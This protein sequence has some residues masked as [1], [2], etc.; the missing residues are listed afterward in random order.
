M[1]SFKLSYWLPFALIFVTGSRPATA[2]PSIPSGGAYSAACRLD[3]TDSY[4]LG[5]VMTEGPYSG[6]CMNTQSRRAAIVISE[7]AASITFANFIHNHKFWTATLK[8]DAIKTAIF[9]IEKFP[10]PLG[11][12]AAHTQLRFITRADA[13]LILQAQSPAHASDKPVEIRSFDISFEYIAPKGIDY[14]AIQGQ[15]DFFNNVGRII[16][17]KSRSIEQVVDAGNTVRQFKMN[18]SPRNATAIALAG[19]RRSYQEQFKFSY[20]TIALNCTTET[21][22]VLDAGLRYTGPVPEFHVGINPIDPIITPSLDAL[23]QRGLINPDG[24]SEIQTAN[25]ELSR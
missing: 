4:D 15:F 3:K 12:R 23:I 14:N 10:A 20:N 1:N 5:P 21:F 19:I 25:Q 13:P 17:F 16:S 6:Q 11:I 18:L 8:K 22:A 7:N 24:S 9:Q 2:A